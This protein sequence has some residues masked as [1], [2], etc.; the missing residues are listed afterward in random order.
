MRA[1]DVDVE[2]AVKA[3]PCGDIRERKSIAEQQKAIGEDPP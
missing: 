2:I 1:G 3:R